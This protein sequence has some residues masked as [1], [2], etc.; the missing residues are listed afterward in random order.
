MMKRIQWIDYARGLA[1]F[2]VVL[3]HVVGGVVNS[4]IPTTSAMQSFGD[5]WDML[6]FR[7]MPL[8]FF[9]SG[10]FFLNSLARPF[11]E[12]LQNKLRTIVYPY[13]VWSMI[14]LVIGSLTIGLRNNSE[15]IAD[16]PRLF[17]DPIL[18]FW[19][20]FALFAIMITAFVAYRAKMNRYLALLLCLL[21]F[22]FGAA[23]EFYTV[24]Y[25]AG[26]ISYF[27]IYFLAGLFFG[28]DF[29]QK[30]ESAALW[31]HLG[32][33]VFGTLAVLFIPMA[34][35]GQAPIYWQ[36]L[37][38]SIVMLI[39]ISLAVLLSKLSIFAFI[40]TWGELSLEIY[41]VHVLALSSVRIVMQ[42]LLHIEN[43]W[44]HIICGVLLGIYLPI[45]V[46]R[47]ADKM[48]LKLLFSAPESL[49]FIDK[50]REQ[51]AEAIKGNS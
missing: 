43:A 13:F 15:T 34:M 39:T 31:Q 25:V 45:I 14:T 24:W 51:K 9:L 30:V 50:T 21:L 22:I 18:H 17:Y 48:G 40:R 20:L 41:L 19:F 4:G 33:I 29:L 12:V 2:A 37:A 44:L 46:K 10:V 5:Y 38:A 42:K 3:W 36:P 11:K 23:T 8:F 49:S 16:F 27:A 32:I 26:Q 6:S 47:L 35:A 7:E 1:I 28:S